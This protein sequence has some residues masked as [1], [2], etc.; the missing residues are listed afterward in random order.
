VR[1]EA[2]EGAGT[3]AILFTVVGSGAHA[4]QLAPT[5]PG[6]Q[7]LINSIA[8]AVAV[9]LAITFTRPLTGGHLNPL[10]TLHAYVSHR[11]DLR[12]TILTIGAQT[13]GALLG[14]GLA[15]VLFNSYAF[16]VSTNSR[17]R[18][19][20]ITGEVITTA[21]LLIVGALS[22]SKLDTQA[23][24]LI[25]S[26][27]GAAYW[28]SPSTAFMNPAATIARTF[29]NSY[30]GIA[31]RSAAAFVAT[32]LVTVAAIFVVIMTVRHRQRQAGD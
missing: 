12:G 26:Y 31:P 24:T 16:A 10:A 14:V 2:I 30:A 7:L 23:G 22:T 18:P 9:A 17:V 1:S 6:L 32:Q 19:E 21:L 15:N 4:Q 27:V 5:S 8:T 20:T 11:V 28:I 3:G 29:T 25:G 13:I